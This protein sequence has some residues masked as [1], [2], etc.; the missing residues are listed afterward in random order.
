VAELAER[1]AVHRIEVVCGPAT[2]G[3]LL[4]ALLALELEVE[5][6]PAERTPSGRPGLYPIDYRVVPALRDLLHGSR[7][8]LVDDAISA[9]SAVRGT[10]ADLDRCHAAPVV[11]G[12]LFVMGPMGPALATERGL[13][14]ERLV[15]LAYGLWPPDTCPH[16]AAGVPLQD[17]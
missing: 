5:F 12:A 8:A 14:L 3:A 4:A 13:P 1:I 10:L 11:L 6:A 15:D 7:V 17:P 16:C 9:G 2:G